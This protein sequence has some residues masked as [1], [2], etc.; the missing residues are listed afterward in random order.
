MFEE[1]YKLH[2]LPKHIISERDVLF[3]SI[4]GNI[5]IN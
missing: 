2:G 3:T 5:C 4:F 1:I